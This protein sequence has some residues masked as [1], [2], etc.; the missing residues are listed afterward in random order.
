MRRGLGKLAI[1]TM[2]CIIFLSIVIEIHGQGS[3]FSYVILYYDPAHSFFLSLLSIIQI[4]LT[5]FLK[6]ILHR[7]SNCTQHHH[8]AKMHRRIQS[9]T[10]LPSRTL[11][12]LLETLHS[13]RSIRQFTN[14]PIS[15]TQIDHLKEVALRAPTS[16]GLNP[17]RFAFVTN[18]VLLSKLAQAKTNGSAFLDNC[19]LAVVISAD[20]SCSDVWIEDCSI[21]AICLQL[22]ATD[23]G[24]GSCWAQIRLRPHDD[25]SSASEFVQSL[26]DMPDNR[27]VVSIIGI[28]H[29]NEKK[30]PHNK[31]DLPWAHIQDFT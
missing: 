6:K 28:G 24:L 9:K 12:M 4:I 17:W 7:Q 16:R 13:R 2:L 22:A 23:L 31:N 25:N 15:Q 11:N 1:L 29:P 10:W 20:T 14:T 5:N 3:F 8:C 27:A 30:E 18:P 19:K 21:A 26:L